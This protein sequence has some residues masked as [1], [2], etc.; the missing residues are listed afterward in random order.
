MAQTQEMMT[1]FGLGRKAGADVNDGRRAERGYHV[2]SERY[3]NVRRILA[4]NL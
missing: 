1:R 2:F 4:V 3:P